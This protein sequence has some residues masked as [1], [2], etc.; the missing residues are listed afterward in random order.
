MCAII[1]ITFQHYVILQVV[2]KD[3]KQQSINQTYI[4]TIT[5]F[6]FVHSSTLHF[7]NMLCFIIKH[8]LSP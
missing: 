5:V 3:V 1:I 8:E 6:I 2:Q 4:N 7:I